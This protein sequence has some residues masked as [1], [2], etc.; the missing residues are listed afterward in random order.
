MKS[1]T[2]R[3]KSRHNSQMKSATGDTIVQRSM[4][5]VERFTQ[6][7]N[8]VC[9]RNKSLHDSQMKSAIEKSPLTSQ[10]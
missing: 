10:M 3:E 9:N 6:W 8:E 7:S 1:A 5:Q 2:D 4:Q